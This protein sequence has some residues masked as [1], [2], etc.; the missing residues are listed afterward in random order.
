VSDRYRLLFENLPDAFAYH[1]LIT[2][3]DGSPEDFVFL[4]VNTAFM[5]MFGLAKERVMGKNITEVYSDIK[6]SSFDWIGTFGKVALT[7]GN[8]RFEYYY[9]PLRRWY[10]IT[11]YRDAPGYFAVIFRD[12]TENK[13]KYLVQCL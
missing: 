12:I 2:D 7:G 4:D 11:V 1:Q 13:R 9:E 3:S 8:I 10:E 5:E 6:E